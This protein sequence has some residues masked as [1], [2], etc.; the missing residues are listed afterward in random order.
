MSP[1][2]MSEKERQERIDSL[3]EQREQLRE[4]ISLLE[5]TKNEYG[6]DVPLHIRTQLKKK[7]ER[8]KEVEQELETLQKIEG[9]PIDVICDLL[10]AAFDEKELKDFYRSKYRRLASKIVTKTKRQKI[11]YIVEDCDRRGELDELLENVR[12]ARPDVYARFASQLGEIVPQ[13]EPPAAPPTGVIRDLLND[14]F[15]DEDFTV[16]CY[17]NF[18]AVHSRF[19]LGMTKTQKI[20]LLI[21]HCQRVNEIDKLLAL[22]QEENPAK[23]ADYADKLHPA[24]VPGPGEKTTTG[25][26]TVAGPTFHGIRNRWALLVGINDYEDRAISDLKVCVSDVVAIHKLI[27]ADARSGGEKAR[28]RLLV[29]QGGHGLPT[30]NEILAGLAALAQ[31]A[32][33]EDMILFYFSGHGDVMDGEAYLLPRDARH[34]ALAVTSVALRDVKRILAGSP[35]HAKVMILDACHSGATIGKAGVKMSAD[36]IRRAFE[37]AEGTA[38]LSSCKQDQVSWEDEDTGRSVFTR[39]LLDALGGEADF[40][41]KGFVTVSDASQYVTDKVKLWAVEH[42]RVQTPTLQYTV[43]GDIILL[44][45]R[46]R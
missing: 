38:V 40:D 24:E 12:Q 46:P 34:A 32:E 8:L 20:Q 13:E 9:P 6:A 29:D 3:F 11:E 22:V 43:A 5:E 15:S 19:A 28:V 7:Q 31:A 37:E 30:R 45:R 10:D 14:A 39:F 44:D 4:S 35:A 21:E 27:A 17:D 26:P 23:Y 2:Y 25:V 42:S 33:P 41:Q 36:F 1:D 16:F 18:P